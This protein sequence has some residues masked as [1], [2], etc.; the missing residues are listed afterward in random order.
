MYIHKCKY[1]YIYTYIYIYIF[2]YT[3]IIS[4]IILEYIMGKRTRRAGLRENQAS[5]P[6]RQARQAASRKAAR[7]TKNQ[8]PR[9]TLRANILHL[10]QLQFGEF[11]TKNRQGAIKRLYLRLVFLLFLLP[12]HGLVGDG[13]LWLL[14]GLPQESRISIIFLE[15]RVNAPI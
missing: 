12:S 7:G 15:G 2:C 1:V 13:L 14:L 4:L 9:T 11:R 5:H 8:E 3:L 10:G 6:Q